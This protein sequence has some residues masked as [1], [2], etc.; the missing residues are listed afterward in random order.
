MDYWFVIWFENLLSF[1]LARL[2]DRRWNLFISK[3][4]GRVL[5]NMFWEIERVI[6]HDFG[7]LYG[8]YIRELVY[9][10]EFG[11]IFNMCIIF[12]KC[13]LDR[14]SITLGRNLKPSSRMFKETL[15]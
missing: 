11:Y 2:R 1:F 3:I 9:I 12:G 8:G 5:G 4:Q 13:P 15:K 6:L 10:S 7:I 14:R